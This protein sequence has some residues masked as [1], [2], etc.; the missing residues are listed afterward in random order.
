MSVRHELYVYHIKKEADKCI[1]NNGL[2]C[3]SR[4]L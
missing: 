1:E 3:M 2:K 4:K